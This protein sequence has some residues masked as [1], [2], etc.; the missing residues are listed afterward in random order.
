MTIGHRTNPIFVEAVTMALDLEIDILERGGQR[1]EDRKIAKT[2]ADEAI[3]VRELRRLRDL[4]NAAEHHRLGVYHN[5]LL[6]AVLPGCLAASRPSTRR[7]AAR[8]CCRSVTDAT[9][10]ARSTS[11][12]FST[13]SSRSS[14]GP[15]RQRVRRRQRNHPVDPSV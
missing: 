10:C 12:R 8:R 5:A 14:P 3:V 13:C 15:R 4:N 7:T 1:L 9:S 11:R 6:Y 2:F